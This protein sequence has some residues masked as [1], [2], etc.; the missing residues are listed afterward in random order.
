M[1]IVH[2]HSPYVAD[3]TARRYQ[4]YGEFVA[5]LRRVFTNAIKYN[6]A[7]L[8]SDKYVSSDLFQLAYLE[9]EN[10]VR[11]PAVI[12]RSMPYTPLPSRIYFPLHSTGITKAVYE[13]A[14]ML[15]ERLEGLLAPFTVHLAD[16]IE[17]ARISNAELQE[18]V[19]PCLCVLLRC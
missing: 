10:C 14:Q 9:L 4:K 19:R 11:Y 13:A 5:D 7:H 15:Q 17:R 18:Q 8:T 6:G 1:F 3:K 12:S 2:P 16:R